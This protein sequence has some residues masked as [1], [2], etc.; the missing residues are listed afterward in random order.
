MIIKLVVLIMLIVLT[1]FLFWLANLDQK[2]SAKE[3]NGVWIGAQWKGC[4][5]RDDIKNIRDVMKEIEKA[6]KND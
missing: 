4:L 2:D 5:T 1:T 6:Q 3:C